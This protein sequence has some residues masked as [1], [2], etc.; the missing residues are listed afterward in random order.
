MTQPTLREETET[1]YCYNHPQRETLLRCNRCERPICNSCAVLTP[2]GYRCVECVR[3]QQKIFNTARPLDY[4]LAVVVAF[5]LSF[6]GSFIA[7][8]L[9]FF[10][11][12]VAPIAGIVIAEAVRLVVSRR[13]SKLLWQLATTA[14][15][16]G[17]LILPGMALLSM[18][19]FGRFSLFALLWPLVYTL[20]VASTVFYRLSGIRM[21]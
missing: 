9:G 6:L 14:A 16:L 10:I 13:R 5:G 12:F 7:R 8:F 21:R 20:M 15:V 1:L 19:A 3:G 17:S 4:I 11:F 18:L 2:T